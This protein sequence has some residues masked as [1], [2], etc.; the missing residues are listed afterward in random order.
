[1]IDLKRDGE[2]ESIENCT[3]QEVANLLKDYVKEAEQE[4]EPIVL[5]ITIY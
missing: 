4:G 3:I 2:E 5:Q 1:M